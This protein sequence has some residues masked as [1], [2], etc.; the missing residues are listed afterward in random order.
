[1]I[2]R[3]RDLIG[4]GKD[5]PQISWR[6]GARIALSFVVNFEEGSERTPQNGDSI[7]DPTGETF[8]VP[9]GQRSLINESLFEYGGRVGFW[10]LLDILGNHDI[11]ATFFACGMAL[12]M[13]P[14]AAREIT[15]NGHEPASH[16]YRWM[17]SDFKSREEERQYI[18][19]AIDAGEKTTG[20]RPLGWFS[21]N[22]TEHTRELLIEEGGFVYDCDSFADDLPYF[23]EVGGQKALVIP[24]DLVNNDGPYSRPPGY[25]EPGDFFSQLKAAF[26]CLYEEG[27]SHPKM[28]SVGLHMR[29]SGRPGRANALE[30]FIRYAKSFPDVWF[31]R[32][33]DIARWWLEHYSHLPT[34]P[35]N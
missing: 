10:R 35:V 20:E 3:A 22:P 32:R 7:A 17:P 15:A 19:R 8:G 16:G 33:I 13:N 4:Y 14:D 24:Y 26:D 9:A 30:E 11:K 2:T 5:Y 23:V 28:M 34:L 27:A 31:A 29:L 25:S 6:D 18:L 1:M 21:V 12:E